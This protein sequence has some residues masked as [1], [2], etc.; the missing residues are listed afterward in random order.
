MDSQD[1][2]LLPIDADILL[3]KIKVFL[4]HI[5]ST[6]KCMCSSKVDKNWLKN[7]YKKKLQRVTEKLISGLWIYQELTIETSKKIIASVAKNQ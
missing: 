5:L 1:L 2:T 6:I 7:F 3:L 4:H